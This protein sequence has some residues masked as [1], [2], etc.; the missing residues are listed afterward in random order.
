LLFTFKPMNE[1][2]ARAIVTWHYDPPYDF[3][4]MDQ[5]PDDLAEFLNPQSWQETNYSVSDEQGQ[6]VGFFSFTLYDATTLEIGLGL[7]PDLTG[8][9]LGIS[10]LQVGLAFGRSKFTPACFVLRVATFNTRAIRTYERAG[11]KPLQTYMQHTN[12]GEYEFLRM[13]RQEK[14]NST[15]PH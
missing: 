11:F 8:K 6:L 4:D 7:R 1:S 2:D 15:E 9:G 10:F 14:P 12:G 3:Y 5:D 13:I